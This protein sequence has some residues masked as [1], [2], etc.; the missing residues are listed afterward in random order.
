MHPPNQWLYWRSDL[1]KQHQNKLCQWIRFY[2]SN[3]FELSLSI[4]FLVCLALKYI[5]RKDFH[6]LMSDR[7]Y[8][9]S[10]ICR[11]WKEK[12][13]YFYYNEDHY[14]MCA[15]YSL[16]C[17]N[18]NCQSLKFPFLSCVCTL[19]VNYFIICVYRLAIRL[20]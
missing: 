15:Q 13:Q 8:Y 7:Y 4:I 3:V 19:Y 20:E 17:L 1:E 14:E 9:R 12:Q 6:N 10:V 11:V 2:G 16:P 18:S 5:I